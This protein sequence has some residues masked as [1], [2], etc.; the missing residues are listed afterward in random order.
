LSRFPE[1]FQTVDENMAD[2]KYTWHRIADAE[3]V[4]VRDNELRI[5]TAGPKK[6]CV[7]RWEGKLYAFSHK[8]PHAGGYLADGHLDARGNIVCPVHRYKYSVKNG[9]NSSGEGYYLSTYPVECRKEGIYVGFS[10]SGLW[11]LFKK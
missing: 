8:C 3:E 4:L 11:G 9:Y 1:E 5:I 10:K 6:V 7:T 2:D